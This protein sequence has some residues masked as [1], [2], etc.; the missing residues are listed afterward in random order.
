MQVILQTNGLAPEG[1]P[2]VTISNAG[3]S[4]QYAG[5]GANSAA[6]K[7][8]H[9]SP[10]DWKILSRCFDS[11]RKHN[12]QWG[13]SRPEAVPRLFPSAAVRTNRWVCS[14]CLCSKSFLWMNNFGSDGL[15]DICILCWKFSLH[16]QKVPDWSNGIHGSSYTFPLQSL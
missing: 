15:N 7:I 11:G 2:K 1:Y 16:F 9:P 14:M 8:R 10:G 13:C 6:A 5:R 4:S 3:L 12:W